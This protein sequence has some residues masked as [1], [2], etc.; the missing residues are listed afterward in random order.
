MK[1]ITGWRLEG[2]KILLSITDENGSPDVD[3]E[4]PIDMYKELI[5]EGPPAEEQ[6]VREIIEKVHGII[7]KRMLMYDKVIELELENRKKINKA[8]N[9]LEHATTK[10]EVSKWKAYLDGVGKDKGILQ[11][12]R[13]LI[14]ALYQEEAKARASL[15][16]KLNAP[17]R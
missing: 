11:E 14:K 5:V 8:L 4:L 10:I 1:L 12:F 17:S 3:V 16:R 6:R 9:G 15:L 13:H 7:N 2:E